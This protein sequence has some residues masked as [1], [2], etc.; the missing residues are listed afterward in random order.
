MNGRT[1]QAFLSRIQ[2]QTLT[3]RPYHSI[4]KMSLYL[5]TQLQWKLSAVT[6]W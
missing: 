4:D 2:T 5:N 6:C 3:L 1:K